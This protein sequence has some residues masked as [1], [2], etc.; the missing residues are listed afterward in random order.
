[1]KKTYII[2]VINNKG[3]VAKTITAVTTASILSQRGYK[4]LLI[5]LDQQANATAAVGIKPTKEM[6]TIKDIFFEG[7]E[8]MKVAIETN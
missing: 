8:L 5:D 2:P 7:K 3:G 6:L 4:T 1:M